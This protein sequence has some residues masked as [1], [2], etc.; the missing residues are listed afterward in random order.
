MKTWYN[1]ILSRETYFS[2]T[3]YELMTVN[4]S[5][6]AQDDIGLQRFSPAKFFFFFFLM[7]SSITI[8][9]STVFFSQF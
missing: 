4:F 8:S 1:F 5:N 9:Y 2:S 6:K 3:L 7:Q